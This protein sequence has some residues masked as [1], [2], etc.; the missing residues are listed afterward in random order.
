MITF[1]S[2]TPDWHTLRWFNVSGPCFKLAW[3]RRVNFLWLWNCFNRRTADGDHW[4]G[5]GVL[6]VGHRHLL[7]MGHSGISIL[8]L[9]RPR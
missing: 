4:W 9:G 2:F 3:R 5:V 7:Y 6:Q 1:H 8:F